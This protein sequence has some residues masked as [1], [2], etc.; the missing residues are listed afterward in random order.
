MAACF[1]EDSAA[2]FRV[3]TPVP[4]CCCR[5]RARRWGTAAEVKH[6]GVTAQW[7]MNAIDPVKDWEAVR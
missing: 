4:W 6:N 5:M 2:K 3:R 7:R 1:I